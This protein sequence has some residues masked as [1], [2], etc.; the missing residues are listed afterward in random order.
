M[1]QCSQTSCSSKLIGESF[2]CNN[3]NKEE[4]CTELENLHID[5][6]DR[7]NTQ[8]KKLLRDLGF[9]VACN[10]ALDA[11]VGLQAAK[12]SCACAACTCLTCCTAARGAL[13]TTCGSSLT[14]SYCVSYCNSA[15]LAEFLNDVK[16]D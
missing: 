15:T 11:Y 6:Q 5:V 3:Q 8:C 16:M 9:S 4:T 10:T 13:S 2:T 14:E 7:I 12:P 1:E